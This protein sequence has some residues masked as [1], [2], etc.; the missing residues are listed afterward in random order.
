[1]GY[2]KTTACLLLSAETI[3]GAHKR[4]L[5]RRLTCFGG[6]EVAWLNFDY[7]SVQSFKLQGDWK[8]AD[9]RG[10]NVF[11]GRSWGTLGLGQL[12]G[13]TLNCLG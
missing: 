2:C 5:R 11:R 4:G 1:M 12:K 3:R 7:G 8:Y 13:W 10:Y 9:N 6:D